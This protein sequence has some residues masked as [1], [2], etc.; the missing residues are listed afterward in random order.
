[1]GSNCISKTAVFFITANCKALVGIYLWNKPWSLLLHLLVT[2]TFSTL[3]CPPTTPTRHHLHLPLRPQ[4]PLFI[5]LLPSLCISGPSCLNALFEQPILA[6]NLHLPLLEHI[7]LLVDALLHQL[8]LLGVVG[9]EGRLLGWYCHGS[10]V[11]GWIVRVVAW[12]SRMK[13]DRIWSREVLRVL[14][15]GEGIFFFLLGLQGHFEATDAHVFGEV[16]RYLL[17]HWFTRYLKL[18]A[19]S[20]CLIVVERE[21][22][23][24]LCLIETLADMRWGTCIIDIVCHSAAR[25][26]NSPITLRT[27][28]FK[29]SISMRLFVD[30]FKSGCMRS[31]VL[32]SCVSLRSFFRKILR[33]M[34]THSW[35]VLWRWVILFCR[36]AV[37][38]Q[39]IHCWLLQISR[40]IEN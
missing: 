9:R 32:V 37:E 5:L 14:G 23:F 2:L 4:P 16:Y 25:L 10:H 21:M 27:V 29:S 36:L 19:V 6:F 13:R 3:R 12:V 35:W 38:S 24:L 28:A 34:A 18:V 22:H 17:L 30:L 15:A 8:L 33:L 31:R 7:L 40:L 26:R 1:M 20:I 11:G 39:E